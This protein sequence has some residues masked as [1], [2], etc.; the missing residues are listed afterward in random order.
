MYTTGTLHVHYTYTIL[1]SSSGCVP[2]LRSTL[3]SRWPSRLDPSS[4]PLHSH[5]RFT[6]P[7]SRPSREPL[8]QR[9]T[10]PH[11]AH[12]SFLTP[13]HSVITA[14]SSLHS[15]LFAPHHSLLTTHSSLLTTHSSLLTLHS[16]LFTPHH[17][18]RTTSHH[19]LLTTHHSPLTTHHSLLTPCDFQA[20]TTVGPTVTAWHVAALSPPL[21][22][23]ML[24]KRVLCTH[25]PRR[26]FTLRRGC[27]AK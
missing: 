4:S 24:R 19:S 26:D 1:Q 6:T 18:P 10:C 14:H 27:I 7:T 22:K 17:S 13:H 15:T 16:S 20:F 3:P 5:P 25:T 21:V 2:S 12:S 9:C 23:A 8:L 11:C